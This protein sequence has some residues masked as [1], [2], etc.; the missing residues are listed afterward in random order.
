MITLEVKFT[1]SYNRKTNPSLYEDSL[2]DVIEFFTN[3]L[4]DACKDEAPVR[5]GN[6]R[7][8]HYPIVNDL[9]GSVGNDVEYA[10]YVI[11]GTSRQAPNNYPQRV[12]NKVD[13]S[14]TASILQQSLI[15]RGVY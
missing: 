13:P 4:V 8:G 15:M 5:T 12:V 9:T 6:L 7:D 3:E 14:K 2:R 11:F 1:D 10:P